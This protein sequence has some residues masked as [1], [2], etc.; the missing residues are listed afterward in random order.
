M[1]LRKLGTLYVLTFS[2]LLAY[3]AVLHHAATAPERV[4]CRVVALAA[5]GGHWL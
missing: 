5:A 2:G 3:H 1:N 4:V